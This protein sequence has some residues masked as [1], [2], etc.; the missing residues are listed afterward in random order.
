MNQSEFEADLLR[1]GYQVVYSGLRPNQN[2]PEHVHG[3]D[4][5]LMVIGG[6]ITITRDGKDET[7]RRGDCC[8]VPAN[9]PHIE[10]AGPQGVAYI[11]GRRAL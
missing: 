5:R 1:E 10:Q 3:W 9:Y 8:V 4:A 7:F 11:A 6:E 2:N